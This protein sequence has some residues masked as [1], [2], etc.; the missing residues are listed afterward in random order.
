MIF[1]QWLQSRLNAHGASIVANGDWGRVS[2][3]ALKVFQKRMGL[4]VTGVA[5]QASVEALRINPSPR[6]PAVVAP[7]ANMPPW[8]AEMHRRMGLHEVR[9][10]AALTAFLKLGRFLGDPRDLPWCGDAVESCMAK[11]LPAE[12]LPGNPFFAQAWASFGVD[13]GGPIVGAIG[14]IRWSPSSGHVGIVAGTDGR[15]VHLLGGNQSNAI[16]VSTFDIGTKD[17]GF[18]AFRWP[19][20][21]PVTRYPALKGASAAV[22]GEGATR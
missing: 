10:N 9:D 22:T 7:T 2:I 17:K 12:P 19:K 8:M 15:K 13:A 20:T 6:A 21:F 18:I 4:A 5:D 16:N 11:V 1:E 3:E 14:V